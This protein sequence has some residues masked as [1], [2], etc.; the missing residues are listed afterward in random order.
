MLARAEV[1]GVRRSGPCCGPCRVLG[2]S[3]LV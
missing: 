3:G 1:L 2:S